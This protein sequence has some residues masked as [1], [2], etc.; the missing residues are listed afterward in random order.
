MLAEI[1]PILDWLHLHPQWGGLITFLI[2]FAECL[3][4][5]GLILPGTVLMTAIGLLIGTGVLPFTTTMLCAI[6]G[7]ILGDMISFW[8][9]HHFHQHLR[10]FWPFSKYPKLLEK[11]EVF[12][13]SHGGK[14]IFLGRFLG[15]IRPMLPV[16]AG[17]LSMSSLRF[18][19]VDVLSAILWAPVY[20]FPGI[21]L[22][23]AS[24]QLPPET[25]TKVL[26]YVILFL[27]FC[28]MVSWVIKK[29][30]SWFTG[31]LDCQVA[32]L[33]RYTEKH[34][35]LTL[36]RSLLI[37]PRNPKNHQQLAL[38]IALIVVV[39]LFTLLALSIYQHGILT[40]YNEPV[41]Y[42]LRSLRT[43]A[44]DRFFI[45]ITLISPTVLTITWLTIVG[46]LFTQQYWRAAWHF[47]GVG[48]LAIGSGT[49]LKHLIHSPRPKGI[50]H[51]PA[52]WSFPS[53]HSTV[54]VAV[55]C[56]LS[57]LLVR[58]RPQHWRWFVYSCVSFI[59]IGITFS[60][61]YLGAH[62]LTDV[63]GGI[64]LGFICCALG[65][66]S[67]RRQISPTIAPTR[68]LIAAL[69]AFSMS[70]GWALYH[71]YNK[72]IEDHTPAWQNQVLHAKHWWNNTGKQPPL[73]RTNRF[74]KPIEIINLQW[75]GSLPAIEKGL[76]QHG[77]SPLPKNLLLRAL[78]SLDKKKRNQQLPILSQLY[79]DRK[80][81]L[82][83]M[84]FDKTMNAL[85]ILRLWDAHLTLH[86]GQPLWIGIVNYHKA[87]HMQ[88]LRHESE[89][90]LPSAPAIAALI[91]DLTEV[92]WREKF[93]PLGNKFTP[94]LF[95]KS[96][97]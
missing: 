2:A 43:T 8:L 32:W 62:W 94:V 59:V 60:R 77:W 96:T 67:F 35:R 86:N 89:P 65:T 55:L 16:I 71:N 76:I 41:Y 10:D 58:D 90:N 7:A 82:V 52:G 53:G 66:L 31:L 15:P 27:L 14:S 9:G 69:L 17:M 26:L 6:A 21:V 30:Y 22:G 36:I 74:G 57:V 12:F 87:W 4:V 72:S 83:M 48:L 78:Y 34:P 54:S 80:P 56:F 44:I 33:W 85:L 46:C 28:W 64:C 93:Y 18:I 38:V 88:F 49:L 11:S 84:K 63:I 70:W 29:L 3:V 20:T 39:V 95:I 61:V 19:V 97:Q 42:F 40:T 75:A 51:V 37:D 1:Q 81:V 24:Q 45:A 23:F 73:Y 79:E 25:A 5:I 91:K 68:M 92:D 47:L 50:F 13:K